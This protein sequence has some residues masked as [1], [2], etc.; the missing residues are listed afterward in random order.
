MELSGRLANR[1]IGELLT[2]VHHERRSGSLV[3]RRSGGEKRVSFRN[4]QIVG[5]LTDQPAEF[6]G[7][8]LLLDGHLDPQRLFRALTVSNEEGK[9]LGRVLLDHRFLPAPTVEETARQQVLEVVCDLFLWKHG[10]FSFQVDLPPDEGVLAAPLDPVELALEGERWAEQFKRIRRT[11]PHDRV[12]LGQGDRW[13]GEALTPRQ[14]SVAAEVDGERTLEELYESVRGSYFRFLD[15][16]WELH[17]AQ[18]LQIDEASDESRTTTLELSLYELLLEQAAEEQVL[19]RQRHPA[20]PL[21]I[22][23][24]FFP[25][26]LDT[27][28]PEERSE[29]PEGGADLLDALDGERPLG[30]LFSPIEARR[31]RQLEL[32]LFQLERGRLALLPRPLS[33]LELAARTRPIPEEER[34][35]RRLFA[36][37]QQA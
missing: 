21:D 29:W 7:R 37:S 23:A 27:P 24:R 6:Y 14:E 28:P 32:F 1:P 25:V 16:A 11:L 36:G 26:W 5:C 31:E 18:V 9:T 35:W 20:L 3:V 30:Q 17:R 19:H 15:A 2:W 10:L 12:V 22:V 8:L 33:E 4:G 34:W 13:P